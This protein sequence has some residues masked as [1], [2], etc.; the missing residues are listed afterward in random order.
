MT[1]SASYKVY[2]VNSIMIQY[3]F[4]PTV[5]LNNSKTLRIGKIDKA[6]YNLFLILLLLVEIETI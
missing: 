2:Q 6:N 1:S 5:K 3:C 4:I